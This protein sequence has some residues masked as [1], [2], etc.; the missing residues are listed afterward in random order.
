MLSIINNYQRNKLDFEIKLNSTSSI[1][2]K[3]FKNK[4]KH[5]IRCLHFPLQISKYFFF[6]TFKEIIC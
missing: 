1:E 3:S 5:E 2:I 4:S 6:C